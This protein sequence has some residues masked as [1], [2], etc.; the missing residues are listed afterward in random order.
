MS[1]A[2][3]EDERKFTHGN[4]GVFVRMKAEEW[5]IVYFLVSKSGCTA[6]EAIRQLIA[7]Q[8]IGPS[9]KPLK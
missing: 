1:R 9:Q 2:D 4:R 5:K 7:R 6:P 8:I 3:G